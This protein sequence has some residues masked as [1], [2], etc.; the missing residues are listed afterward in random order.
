MSAK[1]DF[2][3]VQ[4]TVV[5]TETIVNDPYLYSNKVPFILQMKKD[6]MRHEGFRQYAYP[7]PLSKLAKK[8]RGLD[9]GRRPARELMVLVKDMTEEDGRPWTVG[10]GDTHGVSPD[11]V[12]TLEQAERRLEQHIV[13]YEAAL[14]AALPWVKE[15]SFV[16]RTVLLNMAFNM[17]LRGLLQ[18]RNTLRFIEAKDYVRA[19]SNMTQSLWYKQVGARAKE[20]VERMRTQTIL[21]EHKAKEK[22]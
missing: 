22:L 21:P 1:P 9:W 2:S 18:F 6:L 16:T 5:S 14:V 13:E 11:S 12:R 3:N 7:D 19:A 17:G 8:Y 20:L 10:V 4:S 15:A